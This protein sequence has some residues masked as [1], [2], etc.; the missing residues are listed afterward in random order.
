MTCACTTGIVHVY[1]GTEGR[2]MTKTI[3]ILA[4]V[5]AGKTT[6]S[7]QL[8]YRMG[9]IRTPGRVDHKNTLLDHD[10]MEQ[11]RGITVFSG[12]ATFSYQDDLYYLLD[13]PGHVDF[14]T[15]MERALSVMDYAILLISAA[16]GI[17]PH[18]ETLWHL[19]SV[20][21]VPVFIFLNKCDRQDS[22]PDQV[23]HELTSRFSGEF[24]DFRD[25]QNARIPSA[26]LQEDCASV[27]EPLL[28]AF[29]S[30]TFSPEKWLKEMQTLISRREVFPVFSGAALP[31]DG[32][33]SFFRWFH[34]LTMTDRDPEQPFA[35][36]LYQVRYDAGNRIAFWKLESGL[37][38][39]RDTLDCGDGPEKVMDIRR[40][41]GTRYTTLQEARAGDI[42]GIPM[43]GGH[44]GSIA[45][46]LQPDTYHIAPMMAS[47]VHWDTRSVPGFQM[48][49]NLR[50]LED[51]EPELHVEQ[52][53]DKIRLR[54]MGPMQL[55]MIR[56]KMQERFSMAVEFGPPEIL[57]HETLATSAIGIGHYEPLRHYA[58]VHLRLSPAPRGS[59]IHFRSY[60]H[61]DDLALNWQR[62]IRTHVLE[63]EHKGVLTG[64]PITDVYIDLLCGR[65]HLKHTEG[66]DFR[67]ATYRA[68]RNALMYAQCL[69]LEP[70]CGFDLSVPRD[71]YSSISGQLLQVKAECSAPEF[72]DATVRLRG[73]APY[74]LFHSFQ[75]QFPRLTHGTGSLRI[76]QDHEAVCPEQDR[77]VRETAYAPL[78]DD[79]PD[80]VFCAHGAGFTVHWDHVREWAHVEEPDLTAELHE[81]NL[82]LPQ[83]E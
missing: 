41:N 80:S 2:G 47:T 58:E 22:H 25:S 4:H 1:S 30:G 21:K 61:V 33:D 42:I 50:M 55:D 70:I 28:E 7:E 54:I 34:D 63:K 75:E 78:A 20:R 11:E 27:S 79:T 67:Q 9:V 68:I 5:D 73:Y 24:L 69:L 48:L 36:R 35:A 40:Y 65:A 44:A 59:G 6:F 31:G 45:G 23:F 60:A 19:L 83:Q 46:A 49:K 3:G 13:T 82:D 8:L 15:D 39:I 18:T 38:R 14:A 71:L 29:L 64:S 77:I 72:D 16:D 56:R 66:G 76:W 17:Q 57:Y 32:I 51:E 62:L 12:L 10:P 52:Q 26:R 74:A 53:G 37:L 43:H 81:T